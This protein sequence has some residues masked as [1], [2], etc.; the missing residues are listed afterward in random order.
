M[1]RFVLGPL[2]LGSLVL[3]LILLG[4][5][6]THAPSSA[7]WGNATVVKVT[8]GDTISV[9]VNGTNEKVRL[10]GIDTPET[11]KPDTPVQC[12]G[13]EA[14]AFTA[15]L[16]PVGT[17]VRLE[18]DV[19]PRDKYGRLLAYVYLVADR[20]FVNLQIVRQGYARLLT[21][22]PN[23]AHSDEFVVAARAAEADDIGLW[24]GCTG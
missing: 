22:P 2:V 6:T 9:M 7:S 5:C 3:G 15:S 24:A 12:F 8:D 4:A 14:S 16:L 17:E 13:P 19:E 1:R 11:K 20:T 18:R 21:I 10:I 23:V